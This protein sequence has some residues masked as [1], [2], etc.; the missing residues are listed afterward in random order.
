MSGNSTNAKDL[1]H[2][3]K[4]KLKTDRFIDVIV[5]KNKG[6][7]GV[8]DYKTEK[9]LTRTAGLPPSLK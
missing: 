5:K 9:S 2:A 1:K 4:M 3:D 8:G 7:P 6:H